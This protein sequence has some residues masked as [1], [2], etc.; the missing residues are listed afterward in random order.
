M[1]FGHLM[2]TE[3][4]EI[5]VSYLYSHVLPSV[6]PFC[7]SILVIERLLLSTAISNGDNPSLFKLLDRNK[8][9]FELIFFSFFFLDNYY[10]F[11]KISPVYI[12]IGRIK[13]RSGFIQMT[14]F[15]GRK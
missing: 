10:N 15:N 12:Y 8:A 11:T 4:I 6:A 14:I 13:N 2:N 9:K 5:Q 7:K 3:C 1:Q